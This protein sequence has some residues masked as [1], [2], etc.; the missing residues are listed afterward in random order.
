[1]RSA[2]AIQSDLDAAYA[3]RSDLVAGRG[4]SLVTRRSSWALLTSTE[5]SH[6][7]SVSWPRPTPWAPGQRTAALRGLSS[8]ASFEA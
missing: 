4:P 8:T 1:V 3:A 2:S 6:H 5:P 7:W